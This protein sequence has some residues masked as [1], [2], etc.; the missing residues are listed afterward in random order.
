MSES[1]WI[2]IL[3]C[4]GLIILNC[5]YVILASVF[6]DMLNSHNNFYDICVIIPN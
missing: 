5:M 3:H 2:L 1:G 4:I 6:T